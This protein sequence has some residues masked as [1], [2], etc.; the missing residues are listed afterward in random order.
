MK[1]RSVSEAFPAADHIPALLGIAVLWLGHLLPAQ[2]ATRNDETRLC[3]EL[4]DSLA[5]LGREKSPALVRIRCRDEAGE[6][7][8]TGFLI[9]PAGTVCTLA[10]FVRP[11]SD[12]TI[13]QGNKSFPATLLSADRR[14]GVAFLRTPVAATAFIPPFP[15]ATLGTNAP[16]EQLS[17]YGD[18]AI[19][20]L[21]TT[22]GGSTMMASVSLPFP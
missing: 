8:G 6:I 18:G 13:E 5:R 17:P 1:R 10:E 21:G 19:P 7:I 16:V 11:G 3:S 9:D 22:G 20:L 4:A 15:S 2:A 14:T 12:L